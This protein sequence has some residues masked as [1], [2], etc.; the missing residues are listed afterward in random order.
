MDSDGAV[1]ISTNPDA[2][3]PTVESTPRD[4]P[5]FMLGDRKVRRHPTRELLAA[6]AE[7]EPEP[8]AI[9]PEIRL[10]RTLIGREDHHDPTRPSPF[11]PS[12]R[13]RLL[14]SLSEQL[15][16][17]QTAEAVGDKRDRFKLLGV[18]EELT[19]LA[20]VILDSTEERWI[21]ESPDFISRRL[22]APRHPLHSI[23]RPTESRE[24]HH[25]FP[26]LGLSNDSSPIENRFTGDPPAPGAAD[27]S[28]VEQPVMPGKDMPLN[29]PARDDVFVAPKLLP[30]QSL[31]REI[32]TLE[33]ACAKEATR[34]RQPVHVLTTDGYPN[35]DRYR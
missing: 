15:A 25:E 21:V 26:S 1:V 31:K 12:T 10:D 23:S 19:N 33:I 5:N 8:E 29:P 18:L 32:G 9:V 14:R 20:R 34:T 4:N 28:G 16:N 6:R 7:A 3:S 17:D 11:V 27:I 30:A 22:K 24:H 35:V 13:G 2:T